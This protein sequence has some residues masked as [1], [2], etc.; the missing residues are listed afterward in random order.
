MTFFN[1]SGLIYITTKMKNEFGIVNTTPLLL[2]VIAVGV[3]SFLLITSVA[4]FNDNLFSNLF[5]KDSSKAAE[6]VPPNCSGTLQALVDS[7]PSGGTVNLTQNCTYRETLNVNK[8]LTINGSNQS[9]LRGSDI[10]NSWNQSGSTWVSNQTV[11]GF[12]PESSETHFVDQFKATHPEQV[13]VDG[14]ELTQVPSNPVGNQ[15]A[16]DGSRRVILGTNPS[17]HVVEVTTR[18]RWININSDNVTISGMTLKHAG[19]HGHGWA[20]GNN[21]RRNFIL[22]NSFIADAHGSGINV[23]GGD[24]SST[25]RNNTITRIGCTA[26]TSYQNG[27]SVISGNHIY[28][29]GFG[30]Y[31]WGWQSGGIKMVAASDMLIDNNDV[32]DNG[33]PGIWCD[34][35]CS[36]VTISNNR[37]Y[38]NVGPQIFYEISVGAKI[39][40]NKVWNGDNSLPWPA[41]YDSSSADV[42]IYNN[43]VAFA[44]R[45]IQAYE[46]DR[47]DKPAQGMLNN[48]IHDNTVIMNNDGKLGLMWADYGNGRVTASSSNNRALN[49][50]FWY[51]NPENQYRFQWGNTQYNLI[52][53][54]AQTPG[55]TGSTYI[56]T[57]QKDSILA[58]NNMPQCPTCAIPNPSTTASP[59]PSP[60][61]TPTT[62]PTPTPTPSPITQS[63]FNG[64]HTVPGTT[65]AEDYDNGGEGVSFHDFEVENLGISSGSTYR[66]NLG[67]DTKTTNDTGGGHAIGWGRNG[68]WLEYTLSV[69]TARQYNIGVRGCSGMTDGATRTINLTVNGTSVGNV[70]IPNTSAG[71]NGDWCTFQTVTL[72]NVSL[73]QGN[74]VLRLTSTVGDWWDLNSIIITSVATPT[75]TSTPTPTP[76]PTSSPSSIPGDIDGDRDVDIFDYNALIGNF[77]GTGTNIIG[78]IDKDGDVDIFDYNT[79]IGNFGRTS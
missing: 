11:P 48:Y 65:Q 75:P 49:N 76:T 64:P 39:F 1:K 37:S 58:A 7:A 29:N 10:W 43:V 28:G 46:Q 72:P 32:H 52:A 9:Q 61:P 12:I 44:D 47:P 38:K 14:T 53:N 5:S 45:A 20:I 74:P 23:G 56:T 17:G 67:V 50:K 78:D 62:P 6:F 35:G 60:T 69:S 4:P 26:V 54:F 18:A 13:F 15:F 41:I 34:I 2:I 30:G 59:T 42:E 55:G 40:G 8:P 57:A 25:L 66:T 21:D 16:L 51:P 70:N 73:P 24:L 63:P 77:G 31:D 22:Q 79:L 19:T 3:I 36:N 27:H 68:E 71:P 33:G